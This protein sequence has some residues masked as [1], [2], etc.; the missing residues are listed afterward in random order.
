MRNFAILAGLCPVVAFSAAILNFCASSPA[1]SHS[2]EEPSPPAISSQAQQKLNSL[3]AA[4]RSAHKFHR[5]K[6]E[7]AA[8]IRLGAFDLLI[9]DET[10][11]RAA[12]NQALSLARA[13]ND[14]SLQAA[15]LNGTAD[16]LRTVFS[17][18]EAL[19]TYQQ[20]LDLSKSSADIQNQALALNGMGSVYENIG[21]LQ[22]GLD[23]HNQALALAAPLRDPELEA[24]ILNRIGG[25]NDDLGENQ[26]ALEFYTR[27]LDDWRSAHDLDGEAKALNNIGILYAELGEAPKALDYLLR[28]LPLYRQVGDRA[29]EAGTLN[30]LGTI[31]KNTGES[32]RALSYYRQALPLLRTLQNRIGE[33]SVLNN[34]GNVYSQL[35]ENQQALDAFSQA[36]AIH[37]SL[38]NPE[39][40]AGV[41][42]NIS[43]VWMRLGELQKALDTLQ[44]ALAL[45]NTT[46]EPRGQADTINAI[47][48]VYDDLGQSQQAMEY[49]QR[50]LAIYRHLN[51]LGGQ[52][53]VLNDIAGIY[54][55]PDQKQ[56]ALEI[57]AQALQIER[58]IHDRDG[59]A[60]TLNNMGLVYEDLGQKQKALESYQ[61]ALP[62]WH[63]VG[64]RDGEAQALN[65]IGSLLAD[66]GERDKSRT[67]FTQAL[68]LATAVD[69]PLREAQI[70]HNMMRNE[71]ST[72]PDLAIFYGKQAI[73]LLQQV[74]GQ[75]QGLD[76]ALQRSFLGSKADYYHDLA[77]L[78]I[79]RSRLPE[80][81][82][83][84][85][86]LKQQEYADYVRGETASTLQ[87]LSLTPAEQ[88]AGL[89]Y[90]KSS[91]QIIALGEQWLQLKNNN[92]RTA[93]QEKAYEQL[94]DQLDAASKGLNDFY[95]RLYTAFGSNSGSNRQIADVKGDV[96]R[97]KQALEDSPRTVALYTMVGKDRYRVIVITTATAVAR[98][99]PINQTSLNQK[100]AEFQQ[101]LRNPSRDP[102][103][104]AAELYRILVGPV[105]ADL[106][107]AKA[108]TL[109]WSLDGVLR[110]IPIA[111]LYD[112]GQYLVEKYNTATIT[113]ASISYLD[114]E[115]KMNSL[116]AAAMG[117]SRQYEGDL[118]ALPAVASELDEV[119]KDPQSKD[120]QGALPGT[121]LLNGDFTQKAMDRLLERDFA[122]VHIAS[123]FVY[124]PGDDSQSYLLLAGKDSDSDG[125][126]LTVA[127]FRDD[128]RLSLEHTDLLTLSACDTGMSGS[129]SN[130]REVDGL[131]ATA[132]LRGAKAVLSSLWEVNDASTGAMMAAFYRRWA[133]SKGSVSKVKALRS[134]QLDLLQG[135][136]TPQT[137]AGSRGV[138]PVENM[139]SGRPNSSGFSHPY[140]WAPFV[141]MGNWK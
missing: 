130:G 126:H 93:E 21:Q 58:T 35:G 84:L 91:A 48:V 114:A 76:P 74:R 4:V 141:L 119:V 28:T 37:R 129:A 38:N 8:L 12:Y 40:E 44:E 17:N 140:Y 62:I 83:V 13:A 57:H 138:S 77:A 120:A 2:A 70:F 97:L 31:Y 111:A 112:G 41:F 69:D 49:Y 117:I 133:M 113:P 102:K 131:G 94:F 96:S 67:Y 65:N 7:A 24:Q 85:D 132:Q 59:E 47:G 52:A 71:Q 25:V 101:V 123:H 50:A 137:I 128:Q 79:V 54:N 87:P 29:G 99:F 22:K 108:E 115:P 33:A 30:N 105:E 127:D 90:R 136:I 88:Q 32:A 64:N 82:Q 39:G 95:E 15:A 139:P 51:D 116:S 11:A 61:Q 34:L 27:A 104:L 106:D 118:P 53:T 43:E 110:Y 9:S 42:H 107:Q 26:K 1:Q 103:P 109:V 55:A 81:Q 100:I 16:C 60:R 72:Q 98:E 122:V 18:N 6:D 78:L 66:L 36:L 14:S 121:I 135:R 63:E 56:K 75:I 5:T 89:D 23:L 73:N 125:Y 92:A 134:A 3:Q 86:M 46:G 80:A 20:A 45:W 19:R 68:P 124:R 10:S